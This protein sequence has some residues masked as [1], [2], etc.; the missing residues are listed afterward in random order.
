MYD[1]QHGFRERRSCE[2]QLAMLIEDL[3]RNASL[4]KQTDIILLDFS[5]AIDKVNHSKLLWKLHQYGIRGHVL[6]WIRAKKFLGSRS[7]QVVIDREE[8]EPIAPYQ[9]HL[10]SPRAWCWGRSSSLCILMICLMR[11]ASRFA[12]LLTIQPCIYYLTMEGEDDSSALQTD[13]DI[14]STWESRWDMEFNSSKCQVV[15]VTGTKVPV[16]KTMYCMDRYWSQSQ[17]PD[18]LGLISLVISPGK[19]MST[20]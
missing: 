4:G 19:P 5:K 15:H 6:G 12:C 17:V 8:S 14:L 1:L 11:S 20:V 16:K 7:Q 10:V 3:A 9:S 18:I 13:L 2:T